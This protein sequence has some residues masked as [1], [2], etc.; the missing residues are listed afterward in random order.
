MERILGPEVGAFV[1]TSHES[2]R[3]DLP[4]LGRSVTGIRALRV[5]LD[6]GDIVEATMVI[7][8]I[9]VRPRSAL[10]ERAGLPD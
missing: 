1:H 10:A 8:G 7:V 3:G 9:G 2:S 5:I 6:N 4:P